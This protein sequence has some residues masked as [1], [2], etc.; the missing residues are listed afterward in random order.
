MAVNC[1]VCPRATDGF[2][3]VTA[4]LVKEGAVTVRDVD[5]LMLFR[6][7]VTVTAPWATE[8]A[9]PEDATVAIAAELLVH[10]TEEVRSWVVPFEY[11]PVAV[12]CFV[13]PRATLELDGVTDMLERVAEPTVRGVEPVTPLT[14]AEIVVEP[15]VTA[16]TSPAAD[17]VATLTVDEAHVAVAVRF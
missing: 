6:V 10:V 7:A 16:V 1:F 3:G 15:F 2:A 8:V 17:T 12:I 13:R 4:I 14:I 9:R 5:P 11:V